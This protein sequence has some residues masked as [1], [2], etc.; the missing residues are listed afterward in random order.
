M[1]NLQVN[2]LDSTQTANSNLL[3]KRKLF[4]YCWLKSTTP[5]GLSHQE[6]EVLHFPIRDGIVL[7]MAKPRVRKATRRDWDILWLALLAAA[8]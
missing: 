3:I 7:G 4:S 5:V 6:D 8:C 1:A 2:S